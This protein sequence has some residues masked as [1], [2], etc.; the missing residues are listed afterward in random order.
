MD[1]ER[2]NSACVPVAAANM[3]IGQ[4][5]TSSKFKNLVDS[6][7]H[8][9]KSFL[10]SLI[11]EL[12]EKMESIIDANDDNGGTSDQEL[13]QGLKEYCKERGFDFR[14]LSLEFEKLKGC[15]NKIKTKLKKWVKD[16]L[17]GG[18]KLIAS[19]GFFKERKN[20]FQNLESHSLNLIGYDYRNNNFTFYL[21][22][23]FQNSLHQWVE[24][25]DVKD[26]K[27]PISYGKT[28]YPA[29]NFFELRGTNLYDGEGATHGI[30]ESIHAFKFTKPE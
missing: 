23:P 2:I 22:N 12:I 15:K 28:K 26:I 6:K 1:G 16:R 10:N 25:A 3:L 18:Y 14:K 7:D 8:E 27:K 4:A 17:Q 13:F 11:K 19:V 21:N 29:K 20:D 30:L 5:K 24:L 9:N